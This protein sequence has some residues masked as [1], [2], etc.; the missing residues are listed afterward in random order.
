VGAAQD[1][2]EHPSPQSLIQLGGELTRR[3]TIAAEFKARM[4]RTGR[5]ARSAV[6]GASGW[7]GA[8]AVRRGGT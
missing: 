4:R 3:I 1:R 6:G 5:D 7:L 2:R 8:A